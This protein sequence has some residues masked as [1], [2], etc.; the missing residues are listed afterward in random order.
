VY[1]LT[2]KS[3]AA[4]QLPLFSYVSRVDLILRGFYFIHNINLLAWSDPLYENIQRER[5][6]HVLFA[7]P[8]LLPS[9]GDDTFWPSISL[10]ENVRVSPCVRLPCSSSRWYRVANF[11][12][13]SMY[14][15]FSF[16]IRNS[17]FD[18]RHSIF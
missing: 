7:Y 6:S 1:I 2:K 14:S 16:D 9:Q 3:Q 15:L 11:S 5:L 12:F 18:I 10:G 8:Q 13:F 17:L 4:S